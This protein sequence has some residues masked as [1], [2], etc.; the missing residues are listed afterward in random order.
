[1]GLLQLTSG[2]LVKV[3]TKRSSSQM[4]PPGEIPITWASTVHSGGFW[5]TSRTALLVFH[6]GLASIPISPDFFNNRLQGGRGVYS[7]SFSSLGLFLF[8]FAKQDTPVKGVGTGGRVIKGDKAEKRVAL[9]LL[10]WGIHSAWLFIRTEEARA[11]LLNGFIQDDWLR[12]F[13]RAFSR[14][15]SREGCV[16]ALN[17]LG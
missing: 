14:M 5:Q 17:Q 7:I 11:P 8:L 15:L 6:Q 3:V 1:M 2:V 10:C 9:N 12:R 13:A 16:P 4:E